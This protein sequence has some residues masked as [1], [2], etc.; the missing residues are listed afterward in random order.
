[1]YFNFFKIKMNKNYVFLYYD[2]NQIFIS[3]PKSFNELYENALE[4]LCIELEENQ[5]LIIKDESGKKIT[6][7][8]DYL[9]IV[10]NYEKLIFYIEKAYKDEEIKEEEMNN[11]NEEIKEEEMNNQNE[12]IKEEEMNNQNEEK[13]EEEMNNQNEEIKEEEI[14][15]QNEEIKEEE[16]NYQNEEIKEE[17]INYRNEEIKE[18]EINYRN[19]EIKEEEINYR[20]EE[21][22]EIQMEDKIN[23]QFEEIKVFKNE[24][25]KEEKSKDENVNKELSQY[26]KENEENEI[27]DSEK[28][29]PQNKIEGN[30]I[31][32]NEIVEKIG[33]IF[34]EKF[35]SF[36]ENYK[37]EKENLI[38]IFNEKIDNLSNDMNNSINRI[39]SELNNIILN[40]KKKNED[41]V[42]EFIRILN[43]NNNQTNNEHHNYLLNI[44]KENI[45]QKFK[46]TKNFIS[47]KFSLLEQKIENQ[48]DFEIQELI[49]QLKLNIKEKKL[50]FNLN[51]KYN[52]NNVNVQ[53]F[54]DTNNSNNSNDFNSQKEKESKRNYKTQEKSENSS[55]KGNFEFR[56]RGYKAKLILNKK[57][58][59][60][61]INNLNNE[62][63]KCEIKIINIG[64]SPLPG[65]CFI[66][67]EGEN[68]LIEKTNINQTINISTFQI[69]MLNIKFKKMSN[70]NE[71]IIIKLFDPQK[72]ILDSCDL[73]VE[74]IKN[75]RNDNYNILDDENEESNINYMNNGYVNPFDEDKINDCGYNGIS[76]PNNY[77]YEF[78]MNLEKLKQMFEDKE[79]KELIAILRKTNGNYE[80]AFDLIVG[81]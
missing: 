50:N 4:E 60:I 28:K 67:G 8:E 7:D 13:K 27:I 61:E 48:N 2:N 76:K 9:Q 81:I 63:H 62:S 73:N 35:T 69:I 19:E 16:I 57:P 29:N 46:D 1:M 20:N 66:I 18:E 72:N 51:K 25:K 37:S 30:Q 38:K 65:D 15:Y 80:K 22:N 47:D 26:E 49:N 11:Q 3:F 52:N 53:E 31:C 36:M 75:Y 23:K 79:E 58:L 14:N 68:L 6:G 24:E 10:N 5:I 34:E 42:S 74:I 44:I 43:R 56:E 59:T 40:S 12:E 78:A 71:N 54:N 77:H 32:S 41:I 55:F 21:Q 70:Q 39:E 45:N 17:E 64:N 33:K